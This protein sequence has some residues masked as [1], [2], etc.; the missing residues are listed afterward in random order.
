M[1]AKK[2][3]GILDTLI[4]FFFS[5]SRFSFLQFVSNLV[6]NAKWFFFKYVCVN[7]L[8]YDRLIHYIKFKFCSKLYFDIRIRN[9]IGNRF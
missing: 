2:K 1:F 6:S 7:Y 8:F 9:R 4:M 5:F 3:H